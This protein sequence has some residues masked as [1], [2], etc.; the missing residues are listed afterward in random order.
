M[1]TG[2]RG[3]IGA[4]VVARLRGAGH[5]VAAVGRHAAS[6]AAV[7]ADEQLAFDVTTPEG[8]AAAIDACRSRL[9]AA[10]SLLAH[11]V[12]S[13]LVRGQVTPI[14]LAMICAACSRTSYLSD[15]ALRSL[16]RDLTTKG[17][18]V[19]TKAYTKV[20]AL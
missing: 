15:V 2:A 6:L 17:A 1:V 13:T 10:P 5:R 3:G 14:L 11:C 18:G 12:G 9:G 19:T 7:A 4:E 8:A 16:E 20:R